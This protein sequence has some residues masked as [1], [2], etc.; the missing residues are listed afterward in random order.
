MFLKRVLKMGKM[1]MNKQ[2]MKLS[3]GGRGVE[4]WPRPPLYAQDT[5]AKGQTLALT[6][7]MLVLPW[8]GLST[9]VNVDVELMLCLTSESAQCLLSGTSEKVSWWG[10]AGL[11]W[12]PKLLQTEFQEA[13][14]QPQRTSQQKN[15]W[16]PGN[17]LPNNNRGKTQFPS[18]I[19][20]SE[21]RQ[22]PVT[23]HQTHCANLSLGHHILDDSP[24]STGLLCLLHNTGLGNSRERNHGEEHSA[25]HF[26]QRASSEMGRTVCEHLP[27]PDSLQGLHISRLTISETTAATGE[28]QGQWPPPPPR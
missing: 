15:G 4:M 5:P 6:L 23:A 11:S 7:W 14:Q 20:G 17:R 1:R 10:G 18:S 27:S 16:C 26:A 2:G 22:Q 21:L 13:Q 12:D 8:S 28:V 19:R 9:L 25:L 3:W 24:R